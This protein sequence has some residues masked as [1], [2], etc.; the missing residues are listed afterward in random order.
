M[1]VREYCIARLAQLGLTSHPC[2]VY[3]VS[4]PFTAQQCK[5]FCLLALELIQCYDLPWEEFEL[6]LEPGLYNLNH[7]VISEFITHL[8]QLVKEG[9]SGLLDLGESLEKLLM[10]P[11]KGK[12]MIR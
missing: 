9:P 4:A 12:P 3:D 2:S 8:N 5:D 1:L 11:P 7:K 10:E 6:I